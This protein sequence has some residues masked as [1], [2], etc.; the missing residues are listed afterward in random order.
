MLLPSLFFET[1]VMKK[2]R[3]EVIVTLTTDQSLIGS[4][5]TMQIFAK[6]TY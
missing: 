1:W 2:K 5:L 3:F 6:P 4:S